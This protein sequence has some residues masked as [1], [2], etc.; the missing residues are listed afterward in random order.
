[1]CG[2]RESIRKLIA[3]APCIQDPNLSYAE[4]QQQHQMALAP[5]VHDIRR[6]FHYSS[7]IQLSNELDSVSK[8]F[9]AASFQLKYQMCIFINLKWGINTT[10]GVDAFIYWLEIKKMKIST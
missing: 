5:Y 4:K 3:A 2:Q 6:K 8:V 10:F 9:S 7:P 1:M